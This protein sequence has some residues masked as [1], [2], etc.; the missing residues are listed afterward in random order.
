MLAMYDGLNEKN[1][2][3]AFQMSKHTNKESQQL[4]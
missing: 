4:K 2:T 3:M 1:G